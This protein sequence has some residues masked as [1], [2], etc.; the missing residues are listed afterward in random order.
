MSMSEYPLLCVHC[1]MYISEILQKSSQLF[2]KNQMLGIESCNN[3]F[4]CL[5]GEKSLLSDHRMTRRYVDN[6]KPSMACTVP[7]QSAHCF[8]FY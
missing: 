1:I 6:C 7:I 4:L 3:Q 8:Y 2:V 5:I